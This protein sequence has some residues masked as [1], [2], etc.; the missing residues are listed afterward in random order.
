MAGRLFRGEIGWEDY[1]QRLP[2]IPPPGVDPPE[3]Q[4]DMFPGSILPVIRHVPEGDGPDRT[5]LELGPCLWGFI[6]SWFRG[7][8]DEWK[9]PALNARGD[10]IADSAVFRGA[11]RHHRCLVPVHGYYLWDGAPGNKT[12]FVVARRD[13]DWMCLAALWDRTLLDGSVRDG[14]ALI[15]THPNDAIAGLATHMPVILRPSDWQTWIDGSVKDALSLI[16]LSPAADLSVW[17]S[18]EGYPAWPD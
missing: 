12:R 18:A 10:G 15:T 14:V 11:L 9:R 1:A 4:A 17:P 8:V 2:I 5:A 13:Q 16:A 6:P 7:R 3:Q